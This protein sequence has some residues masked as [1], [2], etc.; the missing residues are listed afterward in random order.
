M[1]DKV[2][3]FEEN[4]VRSA[5]DEE[6][7]E[8]F[9]S[10]IDVVAAL[11]LSVDPKRYWSVLKSRISKELDQPTTICSRLRMK[12][13]D[14]K[15]RL[16]DV[17][18]AEQ[19]LGIIQSIPSPKAE[20][21][22]RWLAR[23]GAE[24]MEEEVDPQKAI[25]RAR[26]TY[27]AKG[28][29]EPWIKARLQGIQARNEL[30]D[31]W[32]AHGVQDQQ[33]AILTNIIHRGTFDLSVREH[34]YLKG[35]STADQIQ[36]AHSGWIFW[37][38][39]KAEGCGTGAPFSSTASSSFFTRFCTQSSQARIVQF[40][41]QERIVTGKFSGRVARSVSTALFESTTASTGRRCGPSALPLACTLSTMRSIRSA[42]SS[43]RRRDFSAT[44][45]LSA[46][47]GS[48]VRRRP[49]T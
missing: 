15:M 24:R 48:S 16:T 32:K 26:A 8:W 17:A 44:S 45:A 41:L 36:S 38:A 31:E 37:R 25:D 40:G 22:K 7:E 33:Y 13:N 10:V 3:L 6:K 30:T 29:P 47:R 4:G 20:P 14:G 1:K 12:A 18:T 21:F 46:P 28:Y 43:N 5:W 23:V 39:S 9:F 35:L 11:T 2:Q 27:L 42:C 19:L 34:K 49:C